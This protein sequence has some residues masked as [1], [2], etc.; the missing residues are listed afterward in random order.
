MNLCSVRYAPGSICQLCARS[1]AP[2][3]GTPPPPFFPQLNET[4]HVTQNTTFL[5]AQNKELTRNIIFRCNC[6]IK[7]LQAFISLT[8]DELI[9]QI[10]LESAHN[11]P[12][13]HL[14]NTDE[15]RRGKL[16]KSSA[17]REH[18][19][20]PATSSPPLPESRAGGCQA[21]ILLPTYGYTVSVIVMSCPRA[22]RPNSARPANASATTITV[23]ASTAG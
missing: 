12:V 14:E 3:I 9:A 1:V 15:F 16:A 10:A 6:E 4:K 13:I 17:P 8:K 20:I 19:R 18:V 11:R 22:S 5:A 23:T 21:V 2:Y 7:V